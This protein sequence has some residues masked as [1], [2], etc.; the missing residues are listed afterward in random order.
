MVRDPRT[1]RVTTTKI[2]SS[3][4][5]LL[6]AFLF[7][8]LLAR[9]VYVLNQDFLYD[10]A[11]ITFRYAQNIIHGHGFAYNPGEQVYGASSPL[12]TFLV[13]GIGFLISP[14]SL[15]FV[16]R[17]T[18]C[19]GILLSVV[20]LWKYLR[21]G[22]VSKIVLATTLLSYPRI[23]YSSIG[24]MEEGLLVLLM[25]LTVA[26]V[27]NR[28]PIWVGVC[29]G[30]AIITKIDALLWVMCILFCEALITKR[31]PWRPVL[32]AVAVIT[33]WVFYCIYTFGNLIPHT[34]EAKQVA[35]SA[36]SQ[37][38]FEE[39]LRL[40]VPDGLE[41]S[42]WM[43]MLFSVFTYGSTIG[44]LLV[45]LRTNNWV[46]ILFPLYCLVY[47]AA[48]FASEF[49]LG[50]W[51]RWIVPMWVF[52]FVS[53][54]YLLDQLIKRTFPPRLTE[55]SPRLMVISPLLLTAVL[56]GPFI[57]HNR[58]ALDVRPYRGIGE[59]LATH[60]DSG[61]GVFLEPIGIIG[62]LTRAY[63]HDFVGLV[64][65]QVTE[66]R[67]NARGSNR[68]FA[69]YVREYRPRFII[70]REAE[71]Q[72]NEFMFAG[73]GDGLLADSEREWF[74]GSYMRVYQ[75]N[76]EAEIQNLVVLETK[77]GNSSK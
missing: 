34:V 37:F 19:I 74:F 71:L 42:P 56:A 48:L 44:A 60:E 26:A 41:H 75:N 62:Y 28:S 53:F 32:V 67:R 18:G 55:L 61:D 29:G 57:Y 12:Y 13:A 14:T 30:L 40:P 69:K 76:A 15:P 65:P 5:R 16:A 27:I 72:N 66:W 25:I 38:G 43:I 51:A 36:H 45:A 6:A 54:S 23:F 24:G 2:A 7:L 21:L 10:D 70:L 4:K 46:M 49:P 58:D 47:M 68:W 3:E 11:Y 35:Y 77:S 73:Y 8:G 33:P 22:L 59:W 50:L 20:L 17:W 63:V 39:V 9:I 31:V 52:V 64:S 1:S